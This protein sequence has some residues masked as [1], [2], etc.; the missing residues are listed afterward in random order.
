MEDFQDCLC[1]GYNYPTEE[2]RFILTG[3]GCKL[4]PEKGFCPQVGSCEKFKLWMD[5]MKF[6]LGVNFADT[7]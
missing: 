3:G 7:R 1:D 2:E 6:F 5:F 4:Y